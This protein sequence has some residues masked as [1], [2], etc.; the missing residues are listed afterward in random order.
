MVHCVDE[1]GIIEEPYYTSHDMARKKGFVVKVQEMY[2]WK[3]M[4][5]AQVLFFDCQQFAD[6]LRNDSTDK[7]LMGAFFSV[8]FCHF[9]YG[10]PADQQVSPTTFLRGLETRSQKDLRRDQALCGVNGHIACLLACLLGLF[11]G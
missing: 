11:V 1:P 4:P 10:I 6:M 3:N 7:R 9:T 5:V 2:K 8:S